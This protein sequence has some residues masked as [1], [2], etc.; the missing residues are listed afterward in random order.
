MSIINQRKWYK[1]MN[2]INNIHM[3]LSHRDFCLNTAQHFRY[4]Q[5][6]FKFLGFMIVM[7]NFICQL[8]WAM[9]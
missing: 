9:G 2:L 5:M 6:K 4:L 3:S 8:D 7:V 1:Q